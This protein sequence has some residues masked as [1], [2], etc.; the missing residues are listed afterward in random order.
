MDSGFYAAVN[1]ARR[2]NMRLDVLS[3][4]LAN[5]NTNGFKEGHI[6][7]D[8]YL[9]SAGPEQHPLPTDTFMGLRGP[10]DIPFP[11]S[12]P[13]SNAYQMT[14]PMA[15]GTED[16]LAQGSMRMTG[17]MYDVAVEGKGFMVVNTPQG[18]RYTRDGSFS[19]NQIGE[20]VTKD[21][22]QVVGQGGATLVVGS[23]KV[24]IGKD[25][26]ISGADG[27]IGQLALVSLPKESLKKEG[28]N[29]YSAPQAQ[30]QVVGIDEGRFSQGFIEGSNANTIRNMTQM[31]ETQRAFEVYMKMLQA[32]DGLDGQAAGSIGKLN[33]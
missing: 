29:F 3:N 19:V 9:T 4:N 33:G 23:G 12:N 10:G 1:G 5:V 17:N 22:Y 32:L 21:G 28:Q 8:S 27:Q 20:L 13:A 25:G 26:T 18:R 14:Y 16:N 31:I 2:M 11:Y 24:S 30:E 7:F 6:N 15:T